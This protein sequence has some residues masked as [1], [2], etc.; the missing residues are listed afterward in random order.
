MRVSK[1][2]Y[3]FRLVLASMICSC[4]MMAS[5]PTV[6]GNTASE[7]SITLQS[8]TIASDPVQL[9]V[10]TIDD[11]TRISCHIQDFSTETVVID[12]I[13]YQKI[14]LDEESNFMIGEAPDLPNI[15]R[16]IMI[17]DATL[18]KLRVLDAHYIDYDDMLIAPSKGSLLRSVHPD[19]V[20]YEF[21]LYYH[22]DT[23]FPTSLASLDEPYILR[24]FRGQVVQLNPFAYN[25]VMQ[26]VRFYYD[27]T[28]EIYPDGPGE[29]NCI[30]REDLPVTLDSEFLQIYTRHFINFAKDRYTPVE[31]QGN[32]V[33][34]AY[35]SFM[36][37]MQPF[38]QWK[39]MKGIPTEMF[40]VSQF[41]SA[42]AIKTFISTYYYDPGVTFV[43][44]VGDVAQVPTL[45]EGWGASDPSYSYI[46][47]SDHYP[48]LFVGRF[49]AENAAQVVTQVERSIDYEK[50][51]QMGASWYHKGAGIASDQGPGDDGEMDYEHIRNIRTLLMDYT[52]SLVDEFYD[53]SQGGEDAPG[54][55]SASML[56]TAVNNGRSVI[57]YCGH[58]WNQGWSTSG[59]DNGDVNNLINDN[60]LPFIWSVACN[61]GEFDSGT[62]FGEAWLRATHNGEPTGA[63]GAFMSSV[64]QY[65]DE[66]MDAQDEFNDL[67][68]EQYVNNVKHTYGGISFNGCMHMNDDY[69]SSGW[70]M[71]DAWILF[72][73]PSLYVRTD[74][75]TSLNVNHET[76][77]MEGATTY[78][79][80]VPGIE[81]ALCAIT[82]DYE[83]L[84]SAYT[85]ESGYALIEFDEPITG[86]DTVDFVVTA[87]NK[88]PYITTVEV[89]GEITGDAN[90]D[91][92]VNVEDLLIVLARWGTSGPEGDVNHDGIVNVEDLLMVLA[93][94]TS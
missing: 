48:D 70:D 93:N 66:P 65:W 34:I 36:D 87:Y 52:Y 58:G 89:V 68:T 11:T 57:N 83:L 39:N 10:D 28:V 19:E 25:P 56:V 44:L 74:T 62:C 4:M 78:E 54:D 61:N 53:G 5:L 86:I 15:R 64:G 22:E 90:G 20:S 7:P 77:I 2:K 72:G 91:G 21:G 94:W 12:N 6:F 84:G 16:S 50:Y 45:Y 27:M 47:G 81:D 75:P 29:I 30:D 67:L 13:E 82:Y 17:P 3:Y 79:V 49:S 71:T 51:P 42:N 80:E 38:V 33:I 31:E 24:D 73:D 23:W 88:A 35:D 40:P 9:A 1:E 92:I 60:M 26:T 46:V 59:F 76:T 32:M 41:G 55:P 8:A 14:V 18:M 43:L 63:I 69:G 37:E 85:D